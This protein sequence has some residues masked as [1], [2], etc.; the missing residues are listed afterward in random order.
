MIDNDFQ[1]TQHCRQDK[2]IQ[3]EVQGEQGGDGSFYRLGWVSSFFLAFS[4][5]KGFLQVIC[6]QKC[7]KQLPLIY[8][9]TVWQFFAM[10]RHCGG[11]RFLWEQHL[12]P[13]LVHCLPSLWRPPA[14]RCNI[15]SLKTLSIHQT[16][17]LARSL[18]P[19]SSSGPWSARPYSKA[20]VFNPFVCLKV[21][22]D[23]SLWYFGGF[24][25]IHNVVLDP[26]TAITW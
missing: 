3:W 14:A 16:T 21:T 10:C 20:E 5:F 7:W 24:Q 8:L 22:Y 23:I 11:T 12:H 19:L 25:P 4:M 13:W 9:I 18:S 17:H 26:I 2:P 6:R 1:M 15:P